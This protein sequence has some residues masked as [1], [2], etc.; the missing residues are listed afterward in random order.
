M[1]CLKDF[2]SPLIV[3]DPG[4]SKELSFFSTLIPAGMEDSQEL[5]SALR[6][7]KLNGGYVMIIT[8]VLKAHQ[9]KQKKTQIS[10]QRINRF[11][12][13]DSGTAILKSGA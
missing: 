7:M 6:L 3:G 11:C 2:L 13:H 5:E 10:F 9:P 4:E 1:S 12:S 8:W